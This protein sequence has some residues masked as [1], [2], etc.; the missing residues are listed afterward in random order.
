MGET[1]LGE[2][3]MGGWNFAPHGFAFCN[4]QLLSISQNTALFSLLGTNFGGDGQTTFGLP[5]L[6]G[7]VPIHWGQGNG[8]SSYNIGQTGGTEAVALVT[9]QMPAHNH[10]INANGNIPNTASPDG[11][12][13]AN[14]PV[15]GSGPNAT[16]LKLY[17]TTAPN[18]A[19][20]NANTM[21]S[22]GGGQAH[23]NI[24]PFMCVTYVIALTGIFPA[25]N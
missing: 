24:Q 8:L 9:S 18:G 3:S 4:G 25:R 12:Y 13:F 11:S 1:Y 22:T 23:T 15:T 14:S 19:V 2:I 6:R 16:Q 5:D 17:Q 20:F 7:R 10:T 21:G